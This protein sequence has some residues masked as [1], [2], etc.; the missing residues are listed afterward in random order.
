MKSEEFIVVWGLS[1]VPSLRDQQWNEKSPSKPFN[2]NF[3]LVA[4]SI[5]KFENKKCHAFI[6]H[7]FSIFLFH[8]LGTCKMNDGNH[9]MTIEKLSK[10]SHW[11]NLFSV[12]LFSKRI[13]STIEQYAHCKQK[14]I[15]SVF[16]RG[17]SCL[18]AVVFFTMIWSFCF[19]LRY[20][21]FVACGK[22]MIH[23]KSIIH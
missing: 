6:K 3:C 19:Q 5:R 18:L 22:Q 16:S 4:Y 10:S 14:N 11:K 1:N 13:E 7:F 21:W 12:Q 2:I 8:I 23:N 17:I 9:C 20:S 15:C